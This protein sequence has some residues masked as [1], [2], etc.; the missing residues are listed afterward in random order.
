MDADLGRKAQDTGEVLFSGFWRALG[1]GDPS[2]NMASMP[3]VFVA[4]PAS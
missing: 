1:E 4:G 3:R 2:G